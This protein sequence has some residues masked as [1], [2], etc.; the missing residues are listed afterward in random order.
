LVEV[1]F[2]DDAADFVE[3]EFAAP[4]ALV[5]LAF[6]QKRNVAE[7]ANEKSACEL[8][9]A[10]REIVRGEAAS[11]VAREEHQ[12]AMLQLVR[13]RAGHHFD[14][15]AKDSARLDDLDDGRI[16]IAFEYVVDGERVDSLD[17]AITA[18]PPLGRNDRPTHNRVRGADRPVVGA[19]HDRR[20]RQCR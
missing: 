8:V 12:V 11:R 2:T 6:V 13:R 15:I 18:S 16:S 3:K 10:E 4:R 14:A 7:I 5:E 20:R 19:Q 9:A 17:A 1:R